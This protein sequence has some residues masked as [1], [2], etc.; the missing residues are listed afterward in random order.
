MKISYDCSDLITELKQDIIEFGNIDCIAF[1]K[2]IE[3]QLVLFDYVFDITD[4]ELQKLMQDKEIESCQKMKAENIYE[5]L[6]E[7]NEI[8]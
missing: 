7:Q 3:G 4:E 1:F 6:L 2:K 5:V 8:I